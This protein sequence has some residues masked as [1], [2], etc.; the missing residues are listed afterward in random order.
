MNF[1]CS[2]SW[3]SKTQTFFLFFMKSNL[4]LQAR[5]PNAA[6][7]CWIYNLIGQVE[8]KQRFGIHQFERCLCVRRGTVSAPASLCS[9]LKAPLPFSLSLS[10]FLKR[11]S[12]ESTVSLSL[13]AESGDKDTGRKQED[14]LVI[15][16]SVPLSSSL[17][18]LNF[19]KL[20]LSF[21]LFHDLFFVFFLHPQQK[22][23]QKMA[24]ELTQ[25]FFGRL[26]FDKMEVQLERVIVRR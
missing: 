16:L 21:F 5:S 19:S 24:L 18:A 11:I 12:A 4:L 2:F 1:N 25:H 15:S 10:H 17:H 6:V 13:L 26:Y 7:V 14:V 9:A 20:Q 3:R 8:I 23:F 22:D